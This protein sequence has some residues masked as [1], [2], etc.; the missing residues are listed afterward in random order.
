MG[1]NVE[2][3]RN[4][5][6]NSRVSIFSHWLFQ[7]GSSAKPVLRRSG[8]KTQMKRILDLLQRSHPR[9]LI[10]HRSSE[11]GQGGCSPATWRGLKWDNFESESE[12]AGGMLPLQLGEVSNEII[13]KCRGLRA[14]WWNFPGPLVFSGSLR[15]YVFVEK[16]NITAPWKHT[17]WTSL[18]PA[19]NII[20]TFI[21]AQIWSYFF[22][23]GGKII[24]LWW[25][26]PLS[27]LWGIL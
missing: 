6:D 16:T 10:R 19:A 1:G 24:Y 11:E 4:F 8:R 2:M 20:I 12:R 26:G 18:L 15:L 13:L 7:K 3:L 25:G 27:I 17:G 5:A 9:N 23:F 14:R 21:G 22:P